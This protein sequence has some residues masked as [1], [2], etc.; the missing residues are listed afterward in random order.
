MDPKIADQPPLFR[1][2]GITKRFGNTTVLQD[3][4]FEG[5]A[6][7]VHILAGENGAGKS[8]LIKILGGIHTD[9]EGRIEIQGREA[10]PRSPLEATALGIAIIHQELSLI[11][12]MSVADNIS[13]GREPT[14][15]GFVL[16]WENTSI[17]RHWMTQLSLDI[18]VRQPVETFSLATRQ[19]IEIAKALSQN[20]RVIVMDEPT[21][22]LN[23]PEVQKLF[24]LIRSLKTRGCCIVYITHKM[25]E[26]DRIADRIT[27]LRD[28]RLIGVAPAPELPPAKF[29]QW[30]V[31]RELAEQSPRRATKLG[32]ELLRLENFSVFP[33]GLSTRPAVENISLSVRA[34][35]VVGLAGLQGSGA[36]EL[37]LGLFGAYGHAT[38]GRMFLKNAERRFSSPREAIASG[39]ALLTND[40][41]TTGLV[42][43]MSVCANATLAGLP[44]LSPGGW[45]SP[46][47]ERAAAEALTAPMRL[48]AASLDIE[49]GALSGGNQQKVALAKCLQTRPQLL[50]LDEP[51]RGID[52]G[53]KREI[54]DLV[55][56]WTSEGMAIL[57]I[58]SEMP[59]LLTLSDR[60]I[61]LHRGRV[62]EVFSHREAKP[63]SIL[64]AAMGRTFTE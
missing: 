23:A 31:G 18:D 34:G 11:G 28:G 4:S 40:R 5:H 37:F 59:E 15:A 58:T 6:G 14:R 35:E 1:L 12:P 48:R 9:F 32:D 47:R 16:Q 24:D 61:V 41:K 42:L 50:M 21:S 43:S 27:V 7:E 38:S 19:M 49:A 54:Y 33:S 25:E 51:T 39:I 46:S 36:S 60:I 56:K 8:T 57:L 52:I 26:I 3:V 55:E 30:M 53:A 64:A 10:R 22:A 17:A 62:I 2:T 45:R 20:A 13:L 29:I 63:E 44:E